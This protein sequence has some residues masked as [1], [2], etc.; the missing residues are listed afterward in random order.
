MFPEPII[1]TVLCYAHPTFRDLDAGMKKNR[2]KLS[3]VVPS[4]RIG[5]N[6]QK[7]EYMEFHVDRKMNLFNAPS[8]HP[9]LRDLQGLHVLQAGVKTGDL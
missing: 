7:L 1:A 8:V 5:S 6:C 4:D 2:A 9:A 3:L